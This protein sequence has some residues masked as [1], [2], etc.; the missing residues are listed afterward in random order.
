M[1]FDV[2]V[3]A[4]WGGATLVN[5]TFYM[6]SASTANT[7][8]TE[9]GA[10]NSLNTSSYTNHSSTQIEFVHGLVE[11]ASDYV[12]NVTVINA[13]GTRMLLA[14]ASLT[15]M[16]VDCHVPQ[17]PTGLTPT[18]DA[19]GTVTFSGTVVGANTTACTLLFSG[20]NPGAT[21]Y[22]MTHS[23]NACTYTNTNVPEQTYTYYIRA[24]DGINTTD[25]STQ[26]LNVDV[27]TGSGKAVLLASQ[28]KIAPKEGNTF[29]IVGAN[30]ITGLGV[31]VII[32]I[33]SG[34]VVAGI[35]LVRKK[36]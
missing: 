20:T 3:N 8:W 1:T 23:A 30:G 25:S 21:S 12:L 5:F 35:L 16:I 11:D 13:S 22:A 17:A 29:S 2:N 31:G 34:V 24:S 4:S 15:G 19:D 14:N 26:T 18:S 33:I 7:T 28:G 9:I 32:F 27:D 10:N 6:G 36:R